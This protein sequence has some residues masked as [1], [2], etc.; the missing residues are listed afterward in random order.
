MI[1]TERDR[2]WTEQRCRNASDA[3]LRLRKHEVLGMFVYT[4]RTR[5]GMEIQGSVS[6]N[7]ALG[8]M[9]ACVELAR[10]TGQHDVANS[11]PR[12]FS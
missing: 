5:A 3:G 8:L 9:H 1:I 12:Y 4:W 10:A 11:C 7:A 6:H 2:K